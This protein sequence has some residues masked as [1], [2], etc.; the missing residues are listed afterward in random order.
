MYFA[1]LPATSWLG[2]AGSS[3]DAHQT[4]LSIPPWINHVTHVTPLT[5]VVI[6]CHAVN[7]ETLYSLQEP[8]EDGFANGDELTPAEEAAAKEA[9]EPKGVVKFGWVKGVLVNIATSTKLPSVSVKREG[10]RNSSW[11]KL[12][13]FNHRFPPCLLVWFVFSSSVYFTHDKSSLDLV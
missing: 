8:F 10:N 12:W 1:I 6:S 11:T 7:D 9:A 2:L 3:P 4:L 5:N 13:C